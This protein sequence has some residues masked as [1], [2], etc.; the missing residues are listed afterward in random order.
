ML[1]RTHESGSISLDAEFY[2][3]VNCFCEFLSEFNGIN[4]IHQQDEHYIEVFVDASL[5]GIG[6]YTQGLVYQST[7]PEFE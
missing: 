1:Q 4:K 7:I 3:D 2:R 6:P 5:T